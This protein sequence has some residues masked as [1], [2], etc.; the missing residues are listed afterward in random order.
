MGNLRASPTVFGSR[1]PPMPMNPRR[2][3]AA[4]VLVLALVAGLP[5]SAAIAQE[6]AM[7]N[8]KEID[9]DNGLRVLFFQ[10]P[11][12]PNVAAGW[13]AQLGGFLARKSDGHPGA[14]TIWRGL[15]RLNDIVRSWQAFG[16]DRRDH[17]H[18][19]RLP[20]KTSK[21]CG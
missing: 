1:S 17:P 16:P 15:Q 18:V 21:T 3:P 5:A 6:S 12:D 2:R 4:L 8:V 20:R 13:I 14:T 11:G 19:P 7:A 10:R 9:L